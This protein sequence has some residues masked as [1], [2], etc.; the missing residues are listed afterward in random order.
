MIWYILI[1]LYFLIV[2]IAVVY[3]VNAG[4]KKLEKRKLVNLFLSIR[5]V[6]I[7]LSFIFLGVYYFV[8][9]TDIKTFALVFLLFYLVSIGFETWYF[10]SKERQL[11]K[12]EKGKEE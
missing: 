9:K 7:I 12:E 2:E 10:I 11:K 1:L 4:F 6:K 3:M 5:V 8:V